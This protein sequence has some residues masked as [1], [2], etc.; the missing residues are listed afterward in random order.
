MKRLKLLL[1]LVSCLL[2]LSCASN[3][4][5]Q[6]SEKNVVEKA[7][8]WISDQ[9]RLELFPESQFVS[10]LAYGNSAQESKENASANVSEYIKS[11]VVSSTT[12]HYFYQENNDSFSETR[13]LQEN[14]SISTENNLYKLEYTNPYYYPDLGQFVCVAFINR[15]QAFNF[16]KPKLDNAKNNFPAAYSDALNKDSLLDK[17]IGIKNAQKILVEFYEV[18]DFARAIVSE[19]TKIYEEIDSLAKDSFVQMRELSSSV[20]MKIEGV[21]DTELLEKSGIISELSNQFEKKGF[22]IGNSLQSNCI[23]LVEVKYSITETKETYEAYPEIS[24]KIIEKG[25]EKISYS[26]KL[27][28][29]AGF[30]KETVIRRTNIA[31]VENIKT[32]FVDECL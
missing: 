11:T 27:S 32:S 7:P 25:A 15:N 6:D 31:L 9:G 1:I 16:V 24:I 23:T 26:K 4:V 17:I 10:Q 21:G 20:L 13:E 8:K 14:V 19:K 28:K 3:K 29:V 12:S 18:Y 30:D 2:G 5:D 22:V